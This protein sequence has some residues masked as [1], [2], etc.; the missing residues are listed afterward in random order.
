MHGFGITVSFSWLRKENAHVVCAATVCAN[1]GVVMA[2]QQELGGES[3]ECQWTF[4]PLGSLCTLSRA[5]Y[6][7]LTVQ[8]H[9]HPLTIS[10]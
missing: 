6:L 10:L 8:Y 5:P 4:L 2:G 7:T 1:V 3:H 9:V